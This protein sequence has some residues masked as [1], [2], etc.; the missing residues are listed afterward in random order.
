MAQLV[1]LVVAGQRSLL[2]R[3]QRRR[4]ILGQKIYCNLLLLIRLLLLVLLFL[5]L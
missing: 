4:A 5:L 2:A 3:A 1:L